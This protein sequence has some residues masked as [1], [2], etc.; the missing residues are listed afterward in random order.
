[1]RSASDCRCSLLFCHSCASVHHVLQ[2][3]F[4][5]F[6]LMVYGKLGVILSDHPCPQ[7]R[8]YF[9][10][11]CLPVCWR[12]ILLFALMLLSVKFERDGLRIRF[13]QV[14][15][16]ESLWAKKFCARWLRAIEKRWV[17]RDGFCEMVGA[18]WFVGHVLAQD[19]FFLAVQ[20]L[21]AVPLSR[22]RS[23]LTD[24]SRAALSLSRAIIFIL[25][26]FTGGPIAFRDVTAKLV[27]HKHKP[28]CGGVDAH[29]HHL[30]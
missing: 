5:G 24:A 6:L 26:F 29:H 16:G 25:I 28:N 19:V 8:F 22:H 1:M 23:I 11:S 30:L 10:T 4:L 21:L 15:L 13:V 17:L 9:L 7:F 12:S 2:G 20:G 27:L 3:V 18:R 14:G